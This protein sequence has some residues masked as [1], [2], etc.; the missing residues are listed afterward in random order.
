MK[1]RLLA[2][3]GLFFVL[4]LSA[5]GGNAAQ[6]VPTSTGATGTPAADAPVEL[7]APA[8]ASEL[9]GL[10]G[11]I[12]IDGSSTV[13]PV[14]AAAAEEFNKYAA[15]VRAPVGVSGTGGGFKK[16]CAGE[17]D[18]QDASRP[19]SPAEVATCAEKNIEY[20]ELPVGYDGLA[21]VVNPQNNWVDNLTV[22]ELKKIWEPEAQGKITNWNQ[23]RASFPDRPLKLFG[24]GTDSGTFDYFTEAIVGKAKSSRG[25]FQASEDDNVLV[26]GVSGDAGALG[27]FGFA[28]YQENADKLKIVP[29][30]VDD[31][32]A[33][34]APSIE[35]VKNASYQPLSRPIFIYVKKSSADRAEVKAFVN[36]YLSKS[37]TPLI[38]SR[39][40]GYISLSDEMYATMAKRFGAG[41]TGTLFPKGAEVGATLDRYAQP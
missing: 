3:L 28:Y 33:A 37:F 30:K 10:S 11:E 5:C 15:K 34:I 38:Q 27:F 2:T 40:V 35:T 24:A 7:S 19:I 20:I 32:A 4:A 14:T 6:S 25:D 22:A 18:I 21:V 17:T 9:A 23:V 12:I 16:F 31:A 29:I 13:Y 39:E 1:S 41:T 36:F 8:N 26:Q